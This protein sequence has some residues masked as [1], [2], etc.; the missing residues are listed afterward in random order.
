M[1]P[2]LSMVMSL[3]SS[4]L[5]EISAPPASQIGPRC[6]GSF[7]VALERCQVEPPSYVVATYM[8]Q[9]PG[10]V[11]DCRLPAVLVPRKA[12]AARLSSPATT[13]EK[14]VFLIPAAAPTSFTSR[15]LCPWS[16]EM[17]MTGWLSLSAKPRYTRPFFEVPTDGSLL[18]AML[19]GTVR[20][21]QV[22]PLSS[23]TTMPCLPPQSLLGTYATPS[24]PTLTWPC[25]PPHWL[26]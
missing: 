25:R 7:G 8:Y 9:T 4:R 21:F 15:Q 6:T 12:K 1:R 14:T 16:S 26:V 17:A 24:G 20:T 2:C 19:F 10:N 5:R 3:K 13:S 22:T 11:C 23:E 18:A